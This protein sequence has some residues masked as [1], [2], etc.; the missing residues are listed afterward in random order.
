MSYG[1]Y[2]VTR[3]VMR[4]M[5]GLRYTD[6]LGFRDMKHIIVC[7]PQANRLVGAP[8]MVDNKSFRWK[9]NPKLIVRN[10]CRPESPVNEIAG[11]LQ[12]QYYLRTRCK[13]TSAEANCEPAALFNLIRGHF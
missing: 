10:K 11:I 1:G 3:G 6:F 4:K 9:V 13:A 2:R 8:S 7:N 5:H 12:R